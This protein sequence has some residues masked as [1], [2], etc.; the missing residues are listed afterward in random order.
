MHSSST[1]FSI[2]KRVSVRQVTSYRLH[3]RTMSNVFF[4]LSLTN[5]RAMMGILA[6]A[7]GCSPE[8]LPS[9]SSSETSILYGTDMARDVELQIGL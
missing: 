4:A 2:W 5:G 3:H 1:N 8:E 6:L 9:S 7:R